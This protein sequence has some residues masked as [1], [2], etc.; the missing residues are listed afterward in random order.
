MAEIRFTPRWREELVATSEK[1]TLIFELTMGKYHVYFPDKT[2]WLAAAPEWA[3][4]KW[5]KYFEACS[6][7]CTQNKIPMTVV[8]DTH[9]YEEK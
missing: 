1:G 7:W 9:I 3:K 2:R 4:T 5:E 6:Q 8:G